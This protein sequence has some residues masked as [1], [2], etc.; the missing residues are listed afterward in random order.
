[1]SLIPMSRAGVSGPQGKALGAE[2][3]ML[4]S[5]DTHSPTQ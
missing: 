4:V 3:S 2:L 5:G 1:M